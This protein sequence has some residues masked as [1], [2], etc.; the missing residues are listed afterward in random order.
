[1]KIGNS[2]LEIFAGKKAFQRLFNIL[3]KV[4]VYGM[5][6][7][8]TSNI[9]KNGELNT[10]KYIKRNTKEGPVIFDV[11]ANVGDYISAILTVF[12]K[13][14]IYGFEPLEMNFNELRKRFLKN[15]Q[16]KLIQAGL[17]HLASKSK[18]HY[19]DKSGSL[20]SMY[21]RRIIH[22]NISLDKSVEI[23]IITLDDYCEQNQIKQIDFLKLDVEGHELAALNGSSKMITQ[24]HIKYI[25]FEFGGTNIDA[26][27]Y[28]QDF[29]YLLNT[30]YRVYRILRDGFE[31]IKEYRE[32]N[33][34]FGYTNYLAELKNST[35]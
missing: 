3:Y 1:M 22:H 29:W 27:T 25:Q 16:V 17:G 26:K 24:G 8:R 14:E 31:E 4:G 9:S 12:E 18:I 21:E 15:S 32:S 6:I 11:G 10:L 23:E 13:V 5:N 35:F 2:I 30:N 33:E 28:F 20:A 19:D 34:I 7:G